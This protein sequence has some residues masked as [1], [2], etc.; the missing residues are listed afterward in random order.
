MLELAL[1]GWDAGAGPSWMGCWSWPW[2]VG[3][4]ELALVGWDAGAGP[5]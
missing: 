4:L 1:A 2:L 3:M 5:G